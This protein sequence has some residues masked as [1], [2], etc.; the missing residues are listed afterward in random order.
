MPIQK[1]AT[2]N[3][4]RQARNSQPRVTGRPIFP[5]ISKTPPEGSP[6]QIG[7]QMMLQPPVEFE[8]KH[9]YTDIHISEPLRKAVVGR[10]QRPCA[11]FFTIIAI[12]V[13]KVKPPS[14]PRQGAKAATATQ[15]LKYSTGTLQTWKYAARLPKLPIFWW[16]K[17]R[18]LVG[19]SLLLEAVGGF[20]DPGSTLLRI[21]SK[22]GR[23][24][25]FRE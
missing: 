19:G 14:S 2:A 1:H 5:Q 3:P 22:K 15:N 21:V 23:Y 12:G 25:T 16:N 8:S 24:G 18:F 4:A 20:V 11:W 10:P 13:P 9:E 7:N 6:I 17:R